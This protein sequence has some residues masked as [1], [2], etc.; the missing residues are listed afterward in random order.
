[1]NRHSAPNVGNAPV[2]D[3]KTIF[4]SKVRFPY[5]NLPPELK[6]SLGT[7]RDAADTLHFT[8]G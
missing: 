8:N 2:T 6:E 5:D 3:A 7:T 4:D 1:M